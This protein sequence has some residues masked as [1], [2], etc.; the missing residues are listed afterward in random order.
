MMKSCIGCKHV[1]DLW[2]TKGS[3]IWAEIAKEIEKIGHIHED[4][5]DDTPIINIQ[6]DGKVRKLKKKS[7]RQFNQNLEAMIQNNKCN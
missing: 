1:N 7:K 3:Y 4:C 6:K 5:E 2:I